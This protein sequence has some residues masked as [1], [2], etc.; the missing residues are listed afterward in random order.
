MKS[1][2]VG[3]VFDREGKNILVLK[4]RDVSMWVFPGGGLDDNETPEQAVV[5]EIYEETGLQVAIVRKT[6]EYTPKNALTSLTHVYECREIKGIPQSTSETRSAGFYPL[7]ALPNPFFSLHKEW[8]DD[9]LLY[10]KDVIRKPIEQITYWK[11]IRYFICHPIHVVRF[12]FSKMG[13]P[14]NSN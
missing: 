4:R 11:L 3:I 9:A 6:A 12:L 2:V 7:T 5:R 14:I 10:E 13:M 1:G 8:L